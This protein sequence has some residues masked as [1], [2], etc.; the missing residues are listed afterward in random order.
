MGDSVDRKKTLRQRVSRTLHTVG[1]L[2]QQPM[3][4]CFIILLIIKFM[5]RRNNKVHS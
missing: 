3:T 4:F 5:K 2:A 1:L